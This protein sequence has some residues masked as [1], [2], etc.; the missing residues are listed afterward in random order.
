MD[1]PTVFYTTAKQESVLRSKTK[2]SHRS[3]SEKFTTA[4]FT[5]QA[6][7]EFHVC[8]GIVV[9]SPSSQQTDGGVY[10]LDMDLLEPMKKWI[11]IFPNYKVIFFPSGK[12]G[13]TI[14]YSA[15]DP[16]VVP[17][18]LVADDD[19]SAYFSM[20]VEDKYEIAVG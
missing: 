2:I 3:S 9:G 15:G 1:P 7:R 12:Y 16:T 6:P 5:I 18:T 4:A 11:Q 19:E 17:A 13:P 10:K 14:H 8:N 20:E